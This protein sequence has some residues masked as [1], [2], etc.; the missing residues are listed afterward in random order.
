MLLL[1]GH[2]CKKE[3]GFLELAFVDF[4]LGALIIVVRTKC[5]FLHMI[6]AQHSRQ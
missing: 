3:I 6:D 5:I 2:D 4:R 1:M